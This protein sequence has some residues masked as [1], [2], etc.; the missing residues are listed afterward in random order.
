MH[1]VLVST[2]NCPNWRVKPAGRVRA[3]CSEIVRP[4]VNKT[5]VRGPYRGTPLGRPR[6]VP[7]PE[8]LHVVSRHPQNTVFGKGGVKR[9]APGVYPDPDNDRKSRVR[10]RG[11]H[12]A[13][14]NVGL[15]IPEPLL[16]H[17]LVGTGK[18][19]K[20]PAANDNHLHVDFLTLSISHFCMI[21]HWPNLP[22]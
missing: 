17:G 5:G 13:V 19:V 4:G 3:R 2:A 10:D 18:G 6:R 15:T 22:L 14:L 20:I 7:D 21:S 11:R 1:R 12:R 9:G 8:P 16:G